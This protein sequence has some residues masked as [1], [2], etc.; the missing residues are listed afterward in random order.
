MVKW[1][2]SC[3]HHPGDIFAWN[4]KVL[5]ITQ[6][7]ESLLNV[8]IISME[9]QEVCPDPG[10]M[11]QNHK[12]AQSGGSQNERKR[13]KPK[14]PKSSFVGSVLEIIAGGNSEKTAHIALDSCFRLNGELMTIPQT[15]FWTKHYGTTF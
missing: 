13:F 2:T 9:E 1:T 10:K 15:D 4:K 12:A 6:E 7:E 11:I 5:N 3:G 8:T 14:P